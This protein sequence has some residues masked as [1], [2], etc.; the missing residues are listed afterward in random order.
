[1]EVS[2]PMG[3]LRGARLLFKKVG[4]TIAWFVLS[5]RKFSPNRERLAVLK[6]QSRPYVQARRSVL[7]LQNYENQSQ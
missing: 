5:L 1:M 4:K 2:L 6:H 3:R 7:L